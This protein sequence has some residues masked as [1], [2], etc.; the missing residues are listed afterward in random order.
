MFKP[1]SKRNALPPTDLRDDLEPEVR[2][3]ILHVFKAHCDG[4]LSD[5]LDDVETL[6]LKAYGH[7]ESRRQEI[8]DALDQPL[9]RV[10]Q[11]FFYC[12]D[13]MAL[14]FVEACFHSR[15]Y[16]GLQH[17][18]DEL[19]FLFEEVGL[20][21]QLTPYSQEPVVPMKPPFPRGVA[22]PSYRVVLPQIIRRD[23]QL[24]HKEIIEPTLQLLRDP[25]LHVAND[26]I[27]RAHAE[28]RAGKWAESI[29]LAGS[30]FEST[31]KTICSERKWQFDPNKDTCAVL[32]DILKTNGLISPFYA[33]PLKNLGTLRNKM[34]AAHGR[35]PKVEYPPQRE[36]AA[37]VLHVASAHI[38]FLCRLAGLH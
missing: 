34:S 8:V 10:M 6:L 30:A 7:L 12:D 19:N 20:A 16:T 22:R 3:R 35:G 33:E 38:L 25:R 14:D 17:G 18:V 23:Q 37:N 15:H 2:S 28:F 13:V 29:S 5:M 27:L 11:H 36:H 1:Y 9:P 26:E 24:T 32:V 4:D 31:M 21:Y